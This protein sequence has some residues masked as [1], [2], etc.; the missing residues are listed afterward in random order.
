[1]RTFSLRSPPFLGLTSKFYTT[2]SFYPTIRSL[3]QGGTYRQDGD[4]V[5]SNRNQREQDSVIEVNY[6]SPFKSHSSLFT[7]P[8]ISKIYDNE[9]RPP[10]KLANRR[11]L[12]D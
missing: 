10:A 3:N 2:P 12:V 9:K 6:D 8:Q 7:H 1:M 4:K 5:C 11:R